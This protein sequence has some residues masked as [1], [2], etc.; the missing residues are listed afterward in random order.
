M[1]A[2]KQEFNV[3]YNQFVNQSEI[4]VDLRTDV[5]EDLM[6]IEGLIDS[7]KKKIVLAD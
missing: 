3:S 1:E 7:V 5:A 4:I 6:Q 2:I